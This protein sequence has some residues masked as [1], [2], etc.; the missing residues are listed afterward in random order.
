MLSRDAERVYWMARYMERVENSAF[1]VNAYSQAILDLPIGMELGWELLIKITASGE[2]FFHRYQNVNER[3]VVKFL[4]ADDDNAGSLYNSVRLARENARTARDL[5]PLE[6]WEILNELYLMAKDSAEKS[7]SRKHRYA[8]LSDVVRRCLQLNGLLDS[9]ITRDQTHTFLGMGKHIER[10]D[11]TSR[12]LDV[13]AGFLL[14][15]KDSP[16]P[17]DTLLWMH[18]LKSLNALL[19][20]RRRMGPR[21]SEAGVLHFLISELQFPRSVAFCMHELE[22]ALKRLPHNKDSL[23]ALAKSAE[24]PEFLSIKNIDASRL[25]DYL[26][27]LQRRLVDLHH[28]INSTWFETEPGDSTMVQAQSQN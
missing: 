3:N 5:I 18:M 12:I 6:G 15:R 26:D 16:M 24:E 9:T 11:M 2:A 27:E 28:A 1:L 23:Q 20:Y 13:G 7:I 21:I 8:Y 14:Q 22:E 19:M 25:H 10:A 4:M 17:F